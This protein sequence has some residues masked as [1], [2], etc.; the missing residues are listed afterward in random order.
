MLFYKKELSRFLKACLP[1]SP[2]LPWNLFHFVKKKNFHKNLSML[3]FIELLIE[4][5]KAESQKDNSSAVELL[6]TRKMSLQKASESFMKN[7]S[8]GGWE[9]H[10]CICHPHEKL[11]YLWNPE[12]VFTNANFSLFPIS[13]QAC[14]KHENVITSCCVSLEWGNSIKNFCCE[15]KTLQF[16]MTYFESANKHSNTWVYQNRNMSKTQLPMPSF[17][18]NTSSQQS[19]SLCYPPPKTDKNE[20]QQLTL[21]GCRKAP[22]SQCMSA[23]GKKR[24][25]RN[26]FEYESFYLSKE[27]SWVE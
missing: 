22:R 27:F 12:K 13:E 7:L 10:L 25:Q 18:G 8:P 17:V 11:Y 21:C 4:F 20:N 26:Q 19:P 23:I 24:H 15:L 9:S 5:S 6:K 14:P 1:S 16:A 3:F 2:S